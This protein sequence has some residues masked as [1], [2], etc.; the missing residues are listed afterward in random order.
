M[1]STVTGKATVMHPEYH[2]DLHHDRASSLQRDAQQRRRRAEA[3]MHPSR[4]AHL[5]DWRDVLGMRLVRVGLRLTGGGELPPD[6]QRRLPHP[7]LA[8]EAVH[9]ESAVTAPPPIT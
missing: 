5:S 7:R 2:L 6:G 1:V 3:A 8:G 4:E 9:R